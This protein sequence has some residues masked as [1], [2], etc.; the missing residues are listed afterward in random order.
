[1]GKSLFRKGQQPGQ[2][3]N[4]VANISSKQLMGL[5]TFYYPLLS[6]EETFRPH[7]NLS[8]PC[9]SGLGEWRGQ[10]G[11]PI[12]RLLLKP[13]NYFTKSPSI[14]ISLKT[15]LG[16]Q[17]HHSTS[18][19]PHKAL[20]KVHSKNK[21]WTVWIS[22]APPPPPPSSLPWSNLLSVADSCGFSCRALFYFYG[23]STWSF[24]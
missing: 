9:E 23:E 15:L 11:D 6:G 14:L 8:G 18:S 2:K 24:L 1:M 13:F 12:F 5:L 20:Y 21:W 7:R 17:A 22:P 3:K 4:K 10:A 16:N 19:C